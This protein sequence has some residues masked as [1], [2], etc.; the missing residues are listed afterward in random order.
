[1]DIQPHF[2]QSAAL[3]LRS[4]F[5]FAQGLRANSRAGC[6][7]RRASGGGNVSFCVGNNAD[8]YSRRSPITPYQIRTCIP[9][10]Q[11]GFRGG[12][13]N[14]SRRPE[15]LGL[16]RN[17]ATRR[18]ALFAPPCAT[19]RPGTPRPSQGS[20]LTS[21]GK[22]ARPRSRHRPTAACHKF[23]MVSPESGPRT[24]R[25]PPRQPGSSGRRRAPG[26]APPAPAPICCSV[27][28]RTARARPQTDPPAPPAEWRNTRRV[29]PT[30]GEQTPVNP[31]ASGLAKSPRTR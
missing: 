30:G 20:R 28:A 29:P 19:P 13:Y 6:G 26:P 17:S 24:A 9:L 4:G 7:I 16:G 22:P 23:C 3:R 5:D 2:G 1:M 12:L 10:R 11:Y 15:I 14:Q 18:R 8:R 31:P 21:S 25:E 27:P